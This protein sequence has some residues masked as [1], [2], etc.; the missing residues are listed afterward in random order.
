MTKKKGYKLTIIFGAFLFFIYIMSTI[1]FG[2]DDWAWG[3]SVGMERL[4]SHFAGYNGRYLGNLLI[5]FLTKNAFIKTIGMA[6]IS[7]AVVLLIYEYI[8][9]D[10]FL[11]FLFPLL[12]LFFMPANV[13]RQTMAWASGL[14]NYIPPVIAVLLYLN[15]VKNIFSQDKPV[16]SKIFIPF[17]FAI[18]ICGN[19][20][21]E[22]NTIL[23]IA[24]SLAIIIYS[25][26]KFKS[27]F[28]VHISNFLGN[29][30]GFVIMFSNSAYGII[31]SGKDSYRSMAGDSSDNFTWILKSI[32]TV[33]SRFI[34][35]NVILNIIISFLLF[36]IVL[37]VKNKKK[38]Y[39]LFSLATFNVCI[40]L[41]VLLKEFNVFSKEIFSLPLVIAIRFIA[42]ILFVCNLAL[43]PLFAVKDK[44]KMFKM[45]VPVFA[46]CVNVT[47]LLIVTPVT[48]RCFYSAYVM[49]IIYSCELLMFIIHNFVHDK[50]V[51]KG[52]YV[53]VII[54]LCASCIF[55]AVKYTQIK[56][57]EDERNSFIIS[58]I[59]SGNKTVYL[60]HFPKELE[61][62][63]EGTTPRLF[64]WYGIWE[65]RYKEF[66]N[67]DN[68]IS[69]QP[70]SYNAYRHIVK[71]K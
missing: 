41:L 18:G 61:S 35:S 24:L 12:L 55:Y 20:F 39:L 36:V 14:A 11:Y 22:H 66:Y 49:M 56:H 29:V 50:N 33:C 8:G 25:Y 26:I 28:A 67:I 53:L 40:S 68:D 30:I 27:V 9:K 10:R 54:A 60:P 69:V 2:S 46:A 45:L 52:L 65:N 21:M 15:I 4:A 6:V 58:Q 57:F 3:T 47:P 1:P 31:S 34:E 37:N 71:A 19:L 38:R 43:I 64:R 51:I 63:T 23:N 16:Y 13:F 62:Y 48:G 17:S 32:D 42:E 7:F 5:I 44:N 59:E 70:I